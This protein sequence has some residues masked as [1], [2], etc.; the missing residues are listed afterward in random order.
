[1]SDKITWTLDKIKAGFDRFFELYQR[2]PTS[3]D[4]DNFDFLPSSR[5]I[6]RKYGGL[7]NLRKM[8]QLEVE[9]YTKG[10]SRS[11]KVSEINKRGRQYE[12]IVF[13]LLKGYFNEVFI[14]VEK[15]T[16]KL[17]PIY[18]SK[19][20]YNFY[21]YAK[22][23]NFAIDVFEASNTRGLI[24]IVNIKEKKYNKISTNEKLYLIYFSENI[25]KIKL[26]NWLGNRRNKLLNKYILL[27]I[28]EFEKELKDYKSFS[29]V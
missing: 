3:Y 1:M 15:P 25:D 17:A 14:H 7:P 21:V 12:N 20:R 24:N 10:Q 28:D 22:P 8:L 18:D 2:Y 23:S 19:D 5:Q 13:N 27:N 4:V 11:D 26:N 9:N 16:S 6:Q 29:L